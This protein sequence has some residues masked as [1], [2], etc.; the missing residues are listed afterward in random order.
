MVSP[1]SKSTQDLPGCSSVTDPEDS[2]V[3]AALALAPGNRLALAISDAKMAGGLLRPYAPSAEECLHGWF[4][5]RAL[6]NGVVDARLTVTQ[7]WV[8]LQLLNACNARG[9]L[10][11]FRDADASVP[12]HL[13]GT[14]GGL[15][16]APVALDRRLRLLRGTRGYRNRCFGAA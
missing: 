6:V 13:L 14:D 8:R 16:A 9:L 1:P 2:D 15:L 3:D 5:N 12:F 4:G 7:G 10:L 11:A